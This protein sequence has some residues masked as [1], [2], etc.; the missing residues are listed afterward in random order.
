MASFCTGRGDAAGDHCCYISGTVCQFLGD[1]GTPGD[2]RFRCLLMVELDDWS[3]VHADE[4][5][6][7]LAVH[8]AGQPLCGDW[9]PAK[10][11]CCREA[12]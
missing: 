6:A 8:W 2:G 1:N 3:K 10:G 4:R 5:Y 7:P 12:R 11:V 9:Q